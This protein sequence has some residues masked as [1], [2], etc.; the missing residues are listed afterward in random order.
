MTRQEIKEERQERLRRRGGVRRREA[1]VLQKVR[2]VV[3]MGSWA[4]GITAGW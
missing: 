3:G 2:R 1:A 4:K